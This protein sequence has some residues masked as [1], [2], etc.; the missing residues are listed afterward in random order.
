MLKLIFWIGIPSSITYLAS[1]YSK[2]LE[3]I[4]YIFALSAFALLVAI[5]SH[6]SGKS[7]S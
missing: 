6:I 5:F 2:L 7:R 4:T 3:N 1:T